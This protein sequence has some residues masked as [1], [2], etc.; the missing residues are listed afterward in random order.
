MIKKKVY[1]KLLEDEIS[2]D[3]MQNT[4]MEIRFD[5]E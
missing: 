5:V 4:R 2:Y 1:D 3:R